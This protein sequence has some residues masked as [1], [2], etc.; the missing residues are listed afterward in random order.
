MWSCK[1]KHNFNLSTPLPF[2]GL[3]VWKWVSKK[4][5][6]LSMLV[7][8]VGFFSSCLHVNTWR[9]GAS[10]D[11]EP[12]CLPHLLWHEPRYWPPLVRL[13]RWKCVRV[14]APIHYLASPAAHSTWVVEHILEHT[15]IITS[16]HQR[17]MHSSISRAFYICV[18]QNQRC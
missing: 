4:K 5:H 13:S 12:H 10:G 14:R 6:L 17:P 15:L 11:N 2:I 1:K 9:P 16:I 8:G 7:L 3:V 18:L